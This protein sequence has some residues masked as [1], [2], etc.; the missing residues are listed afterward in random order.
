TIDTADVYSAWVDGHVG[1]ESEAIIGKWLKRGHVPRDKA[2]V[3]TKV[4]YDNRGR[5][6]GL[7][8]KWITEAVDA[9]L[10]RLGTDYID[11]YL[12]QQPDEDTPH[13][14]S[15]AAF[16]RLMRD[17]KVRAIGCSNFDATQLQNALDVAARSNLP[18]Y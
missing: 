5:K 14:Q 13:E 12:A 9:S 18:R 15:L 3:V 6:T 7:S 10:K 4:G 17:G 8:P 1:G 16:D 11:L 2:I